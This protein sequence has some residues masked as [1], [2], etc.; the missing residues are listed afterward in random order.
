MTVTIAIVGERIAGFPPHVA[1]DAAI[2]HSADA[3]GVDV[4]ARWVATDEPL[5]AAD[6]IWCAPGSPYRSL[7]GALAAL[8]HGREHGIP[9]LGTCGGCQHMLLEFGRNVLGLADAQHAEYDPYASRLFVTPLTCEVAGRTMHV[10]LDPSSRLYGGATAVQEQYYCNFGLNPD[11]REPLDAAGL[12][13]TGVDADGDARVFELEGHPF[14]VATLFV[15]QMRSEPGRP[16]PVVS[17]LVSAAA[18]SMVA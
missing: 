18:A 16:H 1:T 7:D 3:V 13:I 5:P 14:Y 10:T 2:A 4:D 6:A 15:P 9:T 12:R 8:R 17:A 11:Y